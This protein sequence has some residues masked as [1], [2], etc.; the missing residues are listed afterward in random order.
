[1]D[2]VIVGSWIPDKSVIA[3]PI[4]Q[5]VEKYYKGKLSGIQLTLHWQND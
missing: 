5:K 4:I 1:M 2:D 3:M